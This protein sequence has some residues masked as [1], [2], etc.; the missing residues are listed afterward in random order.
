MTDRESNQQARTTGWRAN[1]L[2]RAETRRCIETAAQTVNYGALPG[3]FDRT[4]DPEAPD[5]D[6]PAGGRS[7]WERRQMGLSQS[8]EN[9]E[10]A[11]SRGAWEAQQRRGVN[12]KYPLSIRWRDEQEA[13]RQARRQRRRRRAGFP[14][15]LEDDR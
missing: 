14:I 15:E 10:P 9:A 4:P 12:A 7:A 1:A 2:G 11:G 8:R 6:F 5:E 3:R 13:K